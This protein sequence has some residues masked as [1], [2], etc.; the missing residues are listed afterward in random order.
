[1]GHIGDA[2][3]MAKSLKA[4]LTLEN[5]VTALAGE[6][7]SGARRY[8]KEREIKIKKPFTLTKAMLKK[9]KK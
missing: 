4:T 5:A 3:A 6:P 8:F 2:H 1:M 9:K 7:H